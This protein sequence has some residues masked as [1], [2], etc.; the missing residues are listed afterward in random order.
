LHAHNDHNAR[1]AGREDSAGEVIDYRRSPGLPGVEVIDAQRSPREWRVIPEGFAVVIFRTW[2][3]RALSRGQTHVG[4]PGLAFCN[5]P[6]ELVIGTPEPGPGSF[7]VLQFEPLI[8][9]QWLAEQQP[10]SVRA[11]WAA[12]MRPISARLFRHF[13]DF[14]GVFGASASA[15]E[16][17]SRMLELSELM[18]SELIH[19]ARQPR[20]I[21]G[22]PIRGAARMR[23][24]LNAE[25]LCIDLET[26]AKQAGLSRF[27]ALRAFKQRY[28]L[29]P[30]AYQLCLRISH[31]RQLLRD[32]AAAADVAT[33]CGFAD[34]SHFT[35]HFKRL[36]GV[37][38]MQFARGEAPAPGH[39][40]GVFRKSDPSAVVTGSDR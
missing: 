6:G 30:H 7:N 17:Q 24:C 1:M 20:P 27:Q 29:P 33:R 32:G 12:A 37:T 15:M 14:F 28:G 38:P 25:G 35:R 10:S 4:A 13:S 19:G 34:Q 8:L 5:T 3:G 36:N 18:I 9:A 31:A 39:E 11:D 26:L 23:E 2:H 16:V 40:S 22:P 21:A